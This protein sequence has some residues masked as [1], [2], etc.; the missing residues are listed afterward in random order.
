VTNLAF[1]KHA[2]EEVLAAAE[3]ASGKMVG[4]LEGIVSC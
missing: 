3:G 1:V 2:H 4:L